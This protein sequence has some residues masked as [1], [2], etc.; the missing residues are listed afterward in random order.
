MRQEVVPHEEAHEDPVVH[1]ALKVEGKRQTGHGQ[2]SGQVLRTAEDEEGS[3]LETRNTHTHT[4]HTLTHTHS[5]LSEDTQSDED[6]L[7]LRHW[8]GVGELVVL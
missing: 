5:Y 1:A 4:T 3:V 7:L 6:E 2:F 8:D